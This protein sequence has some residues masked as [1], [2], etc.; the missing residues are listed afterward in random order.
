MANFKIS[1]P[2]PFV[3]VVAVVDIDAVVGITYHVRKLN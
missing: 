2:P 1:L 3:D